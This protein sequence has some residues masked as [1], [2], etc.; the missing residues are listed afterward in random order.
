M[1]G[2]GVAP[3]FLGGRGGLKKNEMEKIA[4]IKVEGRAP[5]RGKKRH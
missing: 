1:R 4:T 3:N 2:T 5:T